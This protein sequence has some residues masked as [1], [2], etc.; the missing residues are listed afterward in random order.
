MENMFDGENASGKEGRLLVVDDDPTTRLF[1]QKLLQPSFD[2][3]LAS[4]GEEALTVAAESPPDLIL[5]DIGM[6]GIDGYETCRRLREQISTPVIFVTAHHTLAE[7]LHAYDS[8]GDDILQK[9]I[10]VEILTRKIRILIRHKV[11]NDQ[12]L[13]EKDSMQKMAMNFLSTVGESGVLLNFMRNSFKCNSHLCLA[14][15]LIEATQSYGLEC[16]VQIRHAGG[17]TQLAQSGFPTPLQ[18]SIMEQARGLGRIFQFSNRMVV[19]YDRVSILATNLPMHEG[20]K[21]GRIR[22]HLSILTESAEAFSEVIDM[23]EEAAKRSDHFEE[24]SIEMAAAIE[25]LYSGYRNIFFEG[26]LLVQEVTD[27]VEKTYPNL[28]MT[29][30]QEVTISSVLKNALQKVVALFDRGSR[31]D[32]QFADRYIRK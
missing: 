28:G 18:E 8:G 4:S 1:L 30:N 17:I 6:P 32:E 13:L 24:N 3:V 5:L 27:L 15:Q 26:H 31:L 14:T 29:L 7:Q 25:T 2:V 22:D 9:P 16:H 19:N 12:L 21:L 23:R 10:D 11:E 20:E